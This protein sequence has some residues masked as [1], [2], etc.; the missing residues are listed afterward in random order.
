MA[1]GRLNLF[2]RYRIQC[3]L[4][5]GCSLRDIAR[6]LDRAPSTIS[7]ELRRNR[8]GARYQPETAQRLSRQRRAKASAVPR[9]NPEAVALIE[10]K[11][12]LD[13]SPEQ[14]SESTGLASHEWI[15]QHI[16][17]DQRRGG[18][19][20]KHLRRRRRKRQRRGLRD[21]RGQLRNQRSIHDRPECVALRERLGDWEIDTVHA[22]SGRAVI[23]TMTERRSRLH[24][25][26]Y[27]PN[28]TADAV[29]RAIVR[30]LGRIRSAVRT[31][32]AD[33]GKEFAEHESIALA[34][35]ADVF[36]ADP[37]APWQRG[38]NENANGLI[39]QYLPRSRDFSLITDEELL[40]IE[41][42]LNTRPRKTLGFRTPLDVFT[43]EFPSTVANQS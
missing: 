22:S 15:Y 37:H 24:L 13:W 42:R 1:V 34:L 11:L 21:G 26:A 3:L 40:W 2:E 19:L 36:F 4:E 32:T 6:R 10:E 23:V 31:L 27:S 35:Q 30:R 7:R 16:Y 39:R 33:N 43:E 25:L 17:A 8:A 18:S 5:T 20:F 38:S 9:I 29:Y 28:R 41:E 14:I 12:R